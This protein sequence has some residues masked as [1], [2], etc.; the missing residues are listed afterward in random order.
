MAHNRLAGFLRDAKA[1][2][3]GELPTD[4]KITQKPR[5]EVERKKRVRSKVNIAPAGRKRPA[6]G[7]WQ[8]TDSKKRKLESSERDWSED[9]SNDSQPAEPCENRKRKPSAE[10]ELIDLYDPQPTKR[11][12]Y[13]CQMCNQSFAA[14]DDLDLHEMFAECQ[15]SDQSSIVDDFTEDD[16]Y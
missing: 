5:S 11:F 3:V 13:A 10:E 9:S 15:Q 4:F 7:G 2:G 6:E 8:A 14:M 16:S 12:R 1:L